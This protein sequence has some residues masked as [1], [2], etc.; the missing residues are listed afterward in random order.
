MWNRH[1]PYSRIG[2]ENSKTVR[3]LVIELGEKLKK[4]EVTAK[5][6]VEFL[7]AHKIC[8][9]NDRTGQLSSNW[10]EPE[11]DPNR[12]VFICVI[13]CSCACGPMDEG[14]NQLG[15]GFK[16]KYDFTFKK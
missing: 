14:C 13:S 11:A 8:F 7:Q 10:A 15:P 2:N 9:P 3:E 5:E 1:N 6:T 12:A 16:P 4:D